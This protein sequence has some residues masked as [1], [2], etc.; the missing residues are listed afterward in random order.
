MMIFFWGQTQ[1]V[2]M[3]H[4][5]SVL[6]SNRNYS[7]PLP[8]EYKKKDLKKYVPSR[9]LTTLSNNKKSASGSG[10]QPPFDKLGLKI[11]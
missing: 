7:M 6:F 3:Y 2:H 1:H 5:I 9:T 11:R 4:D 10:K 8:P